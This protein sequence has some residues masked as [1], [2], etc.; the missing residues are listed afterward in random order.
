[1]FNMPPND[2]VIDCL[3]SS[4]IG[5]DSIRHLTFWLQ[6]FL[7]PSGVMK[8]IFYKPSAGTDFFHCLLLNIV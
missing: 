5:L 1:M 4:R 7:Y 2:N 6:N 3:P 8:L